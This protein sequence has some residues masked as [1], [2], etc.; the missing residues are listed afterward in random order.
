[1]PARNCFNIL[2]CTAGRIL[3]APTRKPAGDSRHYVTLDRVI[4]ISDSHDHYDHAGACFY[5]LLLK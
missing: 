1:M 2:L 3:R 4:V 5:I